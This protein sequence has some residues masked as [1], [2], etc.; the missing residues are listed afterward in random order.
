MS[1]FKFDEEEVNNPPATVNVLK[2][3]LKLL[4][5]WPRILAFFIF[6]LLMGF[7]INRYLTPI[8]KVQARITTKKFSG[9]QSSPI[10]GMIDASFFTNGLIETYEEIPILKSPKRIGCYSARAMT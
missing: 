3:L 1:A 2:Y 6:S 8:Y 4:R 5:R 9:K 7:T 10:P